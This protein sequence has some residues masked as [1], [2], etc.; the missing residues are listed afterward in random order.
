MEVKEKE[1]LKDTV[2]VESRKDS[3]HKAIWPLTEIAQIQNQVQ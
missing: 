3:W 2:G 1:K